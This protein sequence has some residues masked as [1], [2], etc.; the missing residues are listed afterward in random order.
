MW[1]WQG[2]IWAFSSFDL[3]F[4]CISAIS[5]KSAFTVHLQVPTYPMA[6]LRGC[7]GTGCHTCIRLSRHLN[8]WIIF[9]IF[10]TLFFI[11]FFFYLWCGLL[12]HFSYSCQPLWIHCMANGLVWYTTFLSIWAIACIVVCSCEDLASTKIR[13]RAHVFNHQSF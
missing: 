2:Q 12:N 8:G 6:I 3:F 13:Q 1:I 11:L 5:Y 9:V 7:Q 4:V 10:F